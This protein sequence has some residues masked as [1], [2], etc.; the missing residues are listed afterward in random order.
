V[1]TPRRIASH[2]ATLTESTETIARLAIEIKQTDW[3]SG[4]SNELAAKV[5]MVLAIIAATL[6][7]FG[8]QPELG[9]TGQWGGTGAGK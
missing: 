8:R 5:A 3:G 9:P 4:G 7:G 1:S 2:H 6:D